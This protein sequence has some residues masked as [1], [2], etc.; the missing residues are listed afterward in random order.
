MTASAVTFPA[1]ASL[2]RRLL[3]G[4]QCLNVL[5]TQPDDP[6]RGPLFEWC[7]DFN[8]WRTYARALRDDKAG[9]R[10]LSERPTLQGGELNLAA[11]A[12]LPDGTLGREFARYFETNGIAPFLTL[13]E[14]DS[15]EAYLCK[16]YRETHDLLHVIT[17]YPTHFL[18][19]MELQA[20]VWGNLG[21]P[22]AKMIILFGFIERWR[23]CGVRQ[24]GRY[25]QRL[26]AAW[27]RGRDSR[28]MFDLDFEQHWN[29]PVTE[30]AQRWCAPTGPVPEMHYGIYQLPAAA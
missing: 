5:R 1:G 10:L 19:E 27:R 23:I 24:L 22:A 7:L 2:P 3:I 21:L 4:L 17:G 6:V 26:R 14:I 8:T 20:F 15:D 30:L 28:R 16:R 9:R 25:V 13:F 18:G 29:V 11:L 12:A